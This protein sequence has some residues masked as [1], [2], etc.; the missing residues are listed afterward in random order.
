MWKENYSNKNKIV[1]AKV[2]GNQK[3]MTGLAMQL[4]AEF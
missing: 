4:V 1:Q 3:K 2:L